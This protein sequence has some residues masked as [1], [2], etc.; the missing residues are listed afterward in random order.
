MEPEST[1]TSKSHV[2]GLFNVGTESAFRGLS[3]RFCVVAREERND[4]EH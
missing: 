2:A 4:R 1:L 3:R